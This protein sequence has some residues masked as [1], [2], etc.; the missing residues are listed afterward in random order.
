MENFIEKL[1]TVDKK[2]WIGVGIGAAVVIILIIAL[3][4][5]LG[6]KKPTGGNSSQNGTQYGTETEGGVTEVFGTEDVTEVL[7]TETTET[8]M[9]TETEVTESE[10][11][12]QGI[13]GTTVTQPESVGG[14]EQKPVTTT[15]TGQE[16]TG[17][18]TASQPYDI[19]PIDQKFTTPVAIPAGGSLHFNVM[20]TAGKQFVI[21]DADA[22]V[23]FNGTRYDASNGKVSFIVNDS[24]ALPTDFL[25]FEIG[26]KSSVDKTFTIKLYNV[27]GTRENPEVLKSLG[28]NISLKKG[29]KDG[30]TYKYTATQ[31]GTIRFYIDSMTKS[32]I[33]RVTNN[34]TSAQRSYD[35][36]EELYTDANGKNYIEIAV[37]ANDEL[38]I[39]VFAA[40]DTK[41]NYPATDVTW[42]GEYAQ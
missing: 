35:V 16:I 25:H 36:S 12:T 22:Y 42:H 34:S 15:P 8:E 11:Q 28:D 17:V 21:E 20:K 9:G 7:G 19:D 6:G 10:S 1:K 18:G 29:D 13:G 40:P 4:I 41:F 23:I 38:I 24:K 5:G 39:E 32:S 30:W 26:N 27:Y 3:V 37:T 31:S 14:V 2:V 33:I